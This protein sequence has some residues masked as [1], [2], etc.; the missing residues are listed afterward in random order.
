MEC[1]GPVVGQVVLIVINN[2]EYEKIVKYAK[3]KYPKAEA[4]VSA[5]SMQI[6]WTNKKL[7][8]VSGYSQKELV[9]KSI[10]DIVMI[11]AAT[12]MDFISGRSAETRTI[13]TK[14]GKLLKG[15]TDIKTFVFEG[16]PYF[17][18]FNS[19]FEPME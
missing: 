3:K 5:Y 12:L 18:T 13:K 9:D 8:E 16:E 1:A 6:L 7:A 15:T 19:S 14:S 2:M 10:R 11:D 17:V 4:V